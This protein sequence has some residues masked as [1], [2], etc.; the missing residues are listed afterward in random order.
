MVITLV[1]SPSSIASCREGGERLELGMA[2]EC[3]GRALKGSIP[4]EI[5]QTKCICRCIGSREE[6]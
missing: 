3:F 6:E 1:W 2:E 5:G 4:Y